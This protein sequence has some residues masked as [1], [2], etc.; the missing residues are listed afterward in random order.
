MNTQLKS[1]FA[2]RLARFNR[3]TQ[4][5]VLELKDGSEAQVEKIAGE[6]VLSF[7]DSKQYEGFDNIC[8]IVNLLIDNGKVVNLGIT[9]FE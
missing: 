7:Y 1:K 9:D 5:V 4:C 8:K 2:N 6:Y 3:E